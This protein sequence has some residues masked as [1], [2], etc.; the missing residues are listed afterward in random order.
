K[1]PFTYWNYESADEYVTEVSISLPEGVEITEMPANL[2]IQNDLM[3]YQL[4]FEAVS[5]NQIEVR[6]KVRT[7]R[8][9]IP[10]SEYDRLKALA[11]QI[12]EAEEQH[13]VFR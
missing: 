4:S 9:T 8:S 11:Q 6:R 7:N 10:A 1:W 3:D 2:T 5:G 12:L 13:I